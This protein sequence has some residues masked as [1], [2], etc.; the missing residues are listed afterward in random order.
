MNETEPKKPIAENQG[1]RT[2]GHG[3]HLQQ[4]KQCIK[5]NCRRK[6]GKLVRNRC[7]CVAGMGG[8]RRWGG[9]GVFGVRETERADGTQMELMN[10]GRRRYRL[11][12]ITS[13]PLVEKVR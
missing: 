10:M 2:A 9:G 13:N 8:W 7:V 5:V 3:E 6:G 4:E 1:R 11:E 12:D